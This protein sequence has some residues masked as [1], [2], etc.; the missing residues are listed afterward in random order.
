MRRTLTSALLCVSLLCLSFESIAATFVLDNENAETAHR[1][2]TKT[3]KYKK[4]RKH[5]RYSDRRWRGHHARLKRYRAL[6]ARRRAMRSRHVPI[7]VAP[8]DPGLSILP[9]APAGWQ[10][11]SVK[12]GEVRFSVDEG[13]GSAAISVIGRAT[14]ETVDSGRHQ[15]IGGVPTTTLRREVINRMFSEQGWVVNDYQKEMDG[16][17]VYVVVAQSPGRNG[18]VHSR[19]YYFTESD[20]RIYSLSTNSSIDAANRIAEE[21]EKV[22][23]S[24]KPNSVRRAAIPE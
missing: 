24:L 17:S 1:K 4:I 23:N 15:M 19:M 11:S 16:H 7:A 20:G 13:R 10:S 18:D 3:K 21:L 2:I 12:G 22:I 5:R 8:T 14:G 6:Q 9:L